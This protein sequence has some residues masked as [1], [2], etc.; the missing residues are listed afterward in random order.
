MEF[1]NEFDVDAPID[2]VYSAM[3]DLER[4]A[5]AM[6]G[7]EVLEKT[8]DDHYK[9]A[10]K[11]KVGPISMQY[12]GDVEVVEKD[13]EAHSAKLRVQAREARG[14]GT[15][16]ADVDMRLDEKGE[17]THGQMTASVQLAGR[18]AAMGK[19][20]IQDVSAKLVDQFANNLGS[21][22]G[23]QPAAASSTNGGGAAADAPAEPAAP[24]ASGGAQTP[25]GAGSAAG[26][27]AETKAGSAA[28]SAGSGPAS[29]QTWTPPEQDEGVD[30]LGI[31]A[32]VAGDR[33]KDPKVLAGVAGIAILLLWLIGRRS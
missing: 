9:V 29:Q 1:H 6:P 24:P 10:I 27:D 2:E 25:A 22:L 23:T 20:V 12:R 17:G 33:L 13:P 7:A 3:L 30:A 21:M 26:A 14:Q 28:S 19:G 31:A 32:S 4:V 16:S 18:A 15:A 11:V 8:D 5:P